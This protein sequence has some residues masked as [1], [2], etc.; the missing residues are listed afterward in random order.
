MR[1]KTLIA[2]FLAAFFGLSFASSSFHVR[3]VFDG[4]TI[5]LQNGEKVRYLGIDT[6]EM[7]E[8]VEFMAEEARQMDQRPGTGQ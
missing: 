7:G 8:P 2:L 5:Q 4:D 6:P 1:R 3:F